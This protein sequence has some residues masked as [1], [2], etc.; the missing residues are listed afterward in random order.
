MNER[1]TIQQ[2]FDLAMQ[3][4]AAGKLH[5]AEE[6][7]RRIFARQP[8]HAGAIHGL[9][10]IALQLGRHDIALDLFR[11]AIALNPNSV[12]AHSNLGN[13]LREKGELDAAIAAY[14]QVIALQ[15]NLPEAC[16]NLGNALKDKGQLDEAI[17]AYRQAIAKKADLAEAHYNLSIALEDKGLLDEAIVASRRAIALKPDYADA[18]C[19]LANR[20]KDSG[21]LDEAIAAYRQAI[22]LR[23]DHPEAHYNLSSALLLQGDFRQ[24][25]EEY[26][27]RWKWK[28]FPS[29]RWTFPQP[30]WDGS[31]LTNRTILLHPEQGLGDVIQFLRYVPLVAAR[32][33]KVILLC[34]RPLRR[35]LQ[36]TPDI[37]KWLAPDHAV[38][39]FDVHSPLLS[40]PRAFGTTL[41]SIPAKVP[42]LFSDPTLSEPWRARL[43]AYP[44]ALNVGLVWAG[45]P[46]HT[47]D[48]NRSMKLADLAPLL[49]LGGVRFFSLQI[50]DAASQIKTL[51]EGTEL[52]DWTD[53]LNDFA[54]T[55]ALIANLD[56]VI[57]IDTAAAH[58]AGA[59]GKPVW[60]ML[61]FAPD[62]RWMEAR[63]GN[64]PSDS[65]PSALPNPSPFPRSHPSSVCPSVP[66]CLSSS[67]AQL[68]SS[69]TALAPAS[70]W[71]PTMRLFR[72]PSAGDWTSVVAD[73]ASALSRWNRV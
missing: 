73:V 35:L 26:E 55:A 62:W 25:W 36:G 22:A 40:L 44:P 32:E 5:S 12:E 58:L 45:S 17:A 46:T 53:E 43:A 68:I 48:R 20:L 29:P 9:G 41:N 33:G 28:G 70:P 27:W 39:N 67:P 6:I 64:P 66:S 11:R 16:C 4:H 52:I 72:Q 71:Y 34:Y 24:G 1:L 10:V 50:G 30:Q 23:P 59:M 3:R 7:Y 51:P 37:A 56:L 2:A 65:P 13:V 14:R 60:L 63:E 19:N 31:D 15:P 38:P 47:N 49:R 42:Y 57:S 18:H 21:Q 54:D 69:S 61:P 8:E